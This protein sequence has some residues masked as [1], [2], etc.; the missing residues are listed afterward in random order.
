LPRFFTTELTVE[1]YLWVY[2]IVMLVH[3][4]TF[5]NVSNKCYMNT[6]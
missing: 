3:S 4:D 2:M 1:R 6:T 5:H